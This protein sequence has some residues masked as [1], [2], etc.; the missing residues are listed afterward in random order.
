MVK[1]R[2]IRVLVPHSK[3][4]YFVEMGQPRGVAYEALKA[5]E[6]EINKKRGNLKVNVVFFPTTRDQMGK[7]LLGGLGDIVVAGVT[8]TAERDKFVDFTIPT[9][10]KPINEIVVTG[11]QSPQLTSIDDLA[12]KEVFVR[13]TS[14][15]WTHLEQL[16]AR[17]KKEGKA[18]I[19][20]RAAPE[21]LEDEDLLEMLNAGLF[22]IAVVDDYKLEMWSKIFP[23]IKSRPDLAVNTGGELAW[24]I[25]PNS[26]QLKAALDAFLKTHRQGT[27]F[28]NTLMKRYMGSP[29]FVAEARSPAE[30]KKFETVVELFRKY[31]GQYNVDFL[32]MLAQGYQESRLD[33]QVKSPV[34]AIGVMQVMPATGKELAV[35]D[36]KQLE[37]NIHAG[38]KYMRFMID[39]YYKDEPM[40]AL[41][42]GL[43]TFASYNA[44][45]ARIRQLRQEAGRRGLNPNVWFNNVEIVASEKIGAETVTY[46]ANIYKYYVAYK[47]VVEDMEREKKNSRRCRASATCGHRP[48]QQHAESVLRVGLAIDEEAVAVIRVVHVI[49]RGAVQ[50]AGDRR[51]GACAEEEYRHGHA[52]GPVQIA[53]AR[54]IHSDVVLVPRQVEQLLPIGAPHRFLPSIFR[55]LDPPLRGGLAGKAPHIDFDTTRF[56]G[57]I[58]DPLA[59]GRET[60]ASFAERRRQKRERLAVSRRRRDPDIPSAE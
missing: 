1:R 55:D 18:A 15:Y 13:K 30:M 52:S 36:V 28:G 33:Q 4:M 41:N 47:L 11:P 31:A 5:F 50:V 57:G 8:V 56:I 54:G 22:G 39:R 42:K 19:T 14:S 35:G 26:P 58:G 37:P 60:A 34:G 38:V 6:D 40:D 43:F 9:T 29:K 12:G 53:R 16:N 27:T 45:P 3:T 21:D 25:R 44:G 10:T 46:V 51:L 2:L 7:A 49:P 59:I 17:F 23:K 20:L 32:L 48:V 24:A